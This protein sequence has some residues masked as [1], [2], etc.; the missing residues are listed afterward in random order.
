MKLY[1]YRRSS[2][3]LMDLW[4]YITDYIQFLLTPHSCLAMYFIQIFLLLMWVYET[5]VSNCP[6]PPVMIVSVNKSLHFSYFFLM[7]LLC[8]CYSVVTFWDSS[9]GPTPPL[10][11]LQFCIYFL[12]YKNTGTRRRGNLILQVLWWWQADGGGFYS[13]AKPLTTCGEGQAPAAMPRAA[14]QPLLHALSL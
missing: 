2:G 5:T 10:G 13:C 9:Y 12:Y 14:S 7:Y 1:Y 3:W 11:P 4:N 6:L 8:Y